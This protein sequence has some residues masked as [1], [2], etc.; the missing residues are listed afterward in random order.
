MTTIR[1]TLVEIRLPDG[2]IEHR[3]LDGHA[4]KTV[5]RK[6]ADDIRD[7]G[8]DVNTVIHVTTTERVKPVPWDWWMPK[9]CPDP[10][11]PREECPACSPS[12]KAGS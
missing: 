8:A 3:R 5:I 12:D 2:E 4:T 6:L 7:A 10:H 9:A 1:T 11:G